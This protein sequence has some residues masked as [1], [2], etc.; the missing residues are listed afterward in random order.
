MTIQIP[1]APIPERKYPMTRENDIVLI[2]FEDQ[3]FSFARIEDLSP[4]IKKN[5]CQV[6]LLMLQIPLQVVTWTLKEAYIDGAEFTMGGKRMRFEK[7]VVPES[8]PPAADDSGH[9][10]DSKSNIITLDRFKKHD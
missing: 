4:D 3:P 7:V 2:Y 1:A 5:W 9:E 6:K 8:E 10:T